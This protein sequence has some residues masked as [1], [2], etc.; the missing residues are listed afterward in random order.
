MHVASVTCILVWTLLS[1][2]SCVYWERGCAGSIKLDNLSAHHQSCTFSKSPITTSTVTRPS[3]HSHHHQQ[4]HTTTLLTAPQHHSKMTQQENHTLGKL[5]RW[6][7][8]HS[9]EDDWVKSS[10]D[11]TKNRNSSCEAY[12]QLVNMAVKKFEKSQFLHKL[13]TY[14]VWKKKLKE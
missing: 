9:G 6:K 5:I 11:R 4:Q 8:P 13:T 7:K 14:F 3:K 12:C 2:N 10:Q 1:G